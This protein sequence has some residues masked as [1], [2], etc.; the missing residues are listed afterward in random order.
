MRDDTGTSA[1]S[2]KATEGIQWAFEPASSLMHGSVV[3]CLMLVL[4]NTAQGSC[5]IAAKAVTKLGKVLRPFLRALTLAMG[6]PATWHGFFI[7][8]MFFCTP[9]CR[10]SALCLRPQVQQ[11]W[12]GTPSWKREFG[13]I[14]Y[15]FL[16]LFFF[17]SFSVSREIYSGPKHGL[18]WCIQQKMWSDPVWV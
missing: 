17:S 10:I 7:I 4:L 13:N 5:F 6:S 16:L 2:P 12:K 14:L 3:F 8:S 1:I 15:F 18:T 9:C 11:L